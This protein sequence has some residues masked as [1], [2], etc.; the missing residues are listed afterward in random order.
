[1]GSTQSQ[2]QHSAA[3]GEK[4][5]VGKRISSL[6]LEYPDEGKHVYIEDDQRK[7]PY[8]SGSSEN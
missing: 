1:M 8:N 3:D 6:S 5:D 2:I 4:R 7:K